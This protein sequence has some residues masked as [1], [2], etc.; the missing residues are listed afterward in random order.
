MSR[1][2]S[3]SLFPFCFIMHSIKQL[4]CS[5]YR[6]VVCFFFFSSLFI[7]IKETF[8][9]LWCKAS[10]AENQHSKKC[11]WLEQGICKTTSI[12][13]SLARGS[14]VGHCGG[15]KGGEMKSVPG[16]LLIANLQRYKMSLNCDTP[17]RVLRKV[18]LSNL[19]RENCKQL[20]NVSVSPLQWG[21]R[22]CLFQFV[23]T[24]WLTGEI[25]LPGCGEFYRHV[26][27]KQS[28]Q[29]KVLRFRGW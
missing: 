25:F 9:H 22:E 24:A 2:I 15:E 16:N 29:R 18:W 27:K 3:A 19:E 23:N 10:W 21:A 20:V 6:S 28:M 26:N 12:K 4:L 17:P 13:M 14:M 1:K 8:L 11:V 7:F 5:V